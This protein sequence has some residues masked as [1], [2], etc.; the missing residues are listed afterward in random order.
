MTSHFTFLSQSFFLQSGN[1]RFRMQHLSV[2]RRCN[3][4]QYRLCCISTQKLEIACS[5]NLNFTTDQHVYCQGLK[6]FWKTNIVSDLC[7]L[8]GTVSRL[9]MWQPFQVIKCAAEVEHVA[10]EA[11]CWRHK[12][13][14]QCFSNYTRRWKMKWYFWNGGNSFSWCLQG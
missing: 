3:Y 6:I 14:Y 4:C 12:Q 1:N 8:K 2:W 7:N 9:H 11:I 13:H 10:I 5:K